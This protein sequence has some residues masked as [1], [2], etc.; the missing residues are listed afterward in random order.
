MSRPKILVSLATTV[1]APSPL[2]GGRCRTSSLIGRSASV[3][4][5][6]QPNNRRLVTCCHRIAVAATVPTRCSVSR[7]TVLPHFSFF[8]L[9]TTISKQF[10]R[11]RWN[12]ATSPCSDFL[13]ARKTPLQATPGNLWA[14]TWPRVTSSPVTTMEV[15]HLTTTDFYRRTGVPVFYNG[16][17]RVGESG[18]GSPPVRSRGKD[19]VGYLR[20]EVP[21]NLKQN[22][23]LVYNF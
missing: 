15:G 14:I 22:V 17:V 7:G 20:D 18:D 16:G 3:V 11:Q 12:R 1:G 23:K 9:P 4:Q 10:I 8:L 5:R 21:K 6:P 2:A 19:P 13:Q